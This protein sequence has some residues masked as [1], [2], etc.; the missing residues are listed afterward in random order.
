MR[1]VSC[2][3]NNS[4]VSYHD[5]TFGLFIMKTLSCHQENLIFYSNIV[6]ILTIY[7]YH[8]NIV[9]LSRCHNKPFHAITVIKLSKTF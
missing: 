8:D 9:L 6:I 3:H 1:M 4:G 5:E 7:R 2:Y